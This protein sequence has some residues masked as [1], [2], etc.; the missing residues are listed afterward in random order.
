MY[1]SRRL[2]LLLSILLLVTLPTPAGAWFPRLAAQGTLTR[3]DP[4][5]LVGAELPYVVGP[6]ETLVDIARRAGLGF[7]NLLRANP[8][9]DPWTPPAGHELVLPFATLLPEVLSPG[10]TI[11]LAE[12]RLYLLQKERGRWRVRIYP[13]GLGRRGWETA[14]GEFR[15]I[16]KVR[17]PTWVPPASLRAEKPGLPALVPPGP[18]NPLGRYWLGLSAPGIG[19]HGTNRPYGIGR[20][21]SHGC[22]RL[23]PEDIADLASRVQIGTPVRIIN[24]PI[25]VGMHRGRLLAE[26]HLSPLR[27]DPDRIRR[28]LRQARRRG[29]A[30]AIDQTEL[31]TCLQQATGLPTVVGSALP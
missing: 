27:T 4:G 28:A 21:V 9:I 24:Q 29:L 7:E 14:T 12:F 30:G 18:G 16:S 20:R 19:L 17:D 8:G 1:L 31:A 25:K 15:I 23:Y 3:A 26:V 6:G 10:I 22:I 13:V 2:S 5:Q 11:N